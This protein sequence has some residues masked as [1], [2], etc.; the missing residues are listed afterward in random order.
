MRFSNFT[1]LKGIFVLAFCVSSL[2]PLR[3][4][5]VKGYDAF[6][7]IGFRSDTLSEKLGMH[8]ETLWKDGVV[9][10]LVYL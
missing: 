3:I 6:C 4:L 2:P 9:F 10:G 8:G 1:Y 5:Q 7:P